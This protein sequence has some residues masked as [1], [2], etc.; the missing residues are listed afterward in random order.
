MGGTGL[1]LSIVKHL[2]ETAGGQVGVESQPGQGATFWV[3]L[4]SVQAP[5]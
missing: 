4:P 3:K 2:V 1:G 5:A